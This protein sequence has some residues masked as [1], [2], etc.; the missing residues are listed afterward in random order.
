MDNTFH[1]L[2]H[3]HRQGEPPKIKSQI[4]LSAHPS[5]QTVK[6]LAGGPCQNQRHYQYQHHHIEYFEEGRHYQHIN[7]SYPRF[8]AEENLVDVEGTS[9]EGQ[10]DTDE[11]EDE[12]DPRDRSD[13]DPNDPN[14]IFL[15][16]AF[17]GKQEQLD[18]EAK[19][20]ENAAPK[21][22]GQWAA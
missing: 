20:K 2:P 17:E 6:P 7:S 16:N 9:G 8:I 11:D 13:L 3:H 19:E 15:G 14:Q 18:S 4:F 12:A 10:D 21:K 5:V 22:K 1:G